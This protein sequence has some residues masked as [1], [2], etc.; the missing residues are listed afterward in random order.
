MSFV[1]YF[2]GPWCPQKSGSPVLDPEDEGSVS[3]TKSCNNTMYHP[4]TS[5]LNLKLCFTMQTTNISVF[6]IVAKYDKIHI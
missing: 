4:I 3:F 2:E 1:K 6:E 5:S